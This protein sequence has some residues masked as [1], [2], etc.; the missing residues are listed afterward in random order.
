MIESESIIINNANSKIAVADLQGFQVFEENSFVL[1]ELCFSIL[2]NNNNGS[3][4]N[5]SKYYHYIFAPPYEWHH[6]DKKSRA[7]ALWLRTF[8]HGF[9]WN[10]G[11]I[12]YCVRMDYIKPL[13]QE[14]LIILVKGQQKVEWLKS[15]FRSSLDVRNIEDIYVNGS[16]FRLGDEA[17]ELSNAQ[18]CRMHRA[19]KHCA[20]QNVKII[21]NWLKD[22]RHNCV[23]PPAPILCGH[24]C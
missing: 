1:K 14:N 10:Q 24:G 6:L 16:N 15:V 20:K 21:E 19:V 5:Q 2:N 4:N 22:Y 23:T 17:N 12:P 13:L 9:F 8:H 7:S 3:K 11:E 18:H